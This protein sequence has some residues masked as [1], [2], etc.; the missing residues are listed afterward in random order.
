RDLP[1]PDPRPVAERASAIAPPRRHPH[2]TPLDRPGVQIVW[3][4]QI[5]RAVRIVRIVRTT[6]RSERLERS[7]SGFQDADPR[8][9]VTE[10]GADAGAMRDASAGTEE[11]V[12]GAA[13]EKRAAPSRIGARAGDILTRNPDRVAI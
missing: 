6:E 3:A 10:R 7:G 1:E 9:P 2:G 11:V 8:R 4:V 5:V 12:A 13:R